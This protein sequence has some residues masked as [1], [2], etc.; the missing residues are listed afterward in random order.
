MLSEIFTAHARTLDDNTP[1][2][3]PNLKTFKMLLKK[4]KSKTNDKFIKKFDI[5]HTLRIISNNKICLQYDSG[6]ED[7]HIFFI[8]YVLSS[9]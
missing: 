8:F 9:K 5:L 4:E 2:N 1:S 6:L 7:K 3:L